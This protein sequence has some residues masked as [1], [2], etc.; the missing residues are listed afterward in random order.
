M[1]N[2]G[3]RGRAEKVTREEMDDTRAQPQRAVR[4]QE[5]GFFDR[6]IPGDPLRRVR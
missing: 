1:V 3:E 5:N 2:G 6:E 4:S